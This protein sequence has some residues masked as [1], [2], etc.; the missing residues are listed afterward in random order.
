[1]SERVAERLAQDG[2]R[3]RT[4]T[5]KVRYPD[6]QLRSRSA[7]TAAGVEQAGEIGAARG[8]GAEPVRSQTGRRRCGCSGSRSRGS[9]SS[10]SS[11]WSSTRSGP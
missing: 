10:D 6:F 5:V 2:R 1:M 4:V 3:A 9:A 11:R 7:S 8:A